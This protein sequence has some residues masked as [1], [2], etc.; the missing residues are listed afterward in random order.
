MARFRGD[1]TVNTLI[2]AAVAAIGI[3]YFVPR[4]I[5]GTAPGWPGQATSAQNQTASGATAG[6]KSGSGATP[7]PRS[8]WATSAPGRIEPVGGEVRLASQMPGRV[9]QVLVSVADKVQAG[10][11]LVK[12]DS[13]EL[14]ARVAAA[15]AEAAVRRRDRDQET[16]GRV[17]TERRT[18]EDAVATAERNA[19]NQRIELDRLVIAQRAGSAN[20]DAVK[21]ARD[22]L[23]ATRDKV[24]QSRAQLRKVLATEGM[25]LQTRLE[26]ALAGARA[27]LALADAMLERAHIRAP[28]SGSILQVFATAGEGVAPSP[29]SVL[30]VMGDVTSLRVRAEVEERDASKVRIGQPAVV[31]SDAVPGKDFTGKISSMAQALTPSRLGAKGP[32]KATDVD[33][34]ELIIDLDGQP[35]LLPG[36]RVDVFVKPDSTAQAAPRSN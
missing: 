5:A 11:L 8:V 1:S 9:A 3:A 33:V 30:L 4:Y 14:E 35:P 2:I 7:A 13:G 12:L 21:K 19:A 36:M 10:D 29:E 24:E 26:A 16:V 28:K 6:E 34:L 22:L 17:A 31:R 32:R 27:E 18:A 20:A 23:T 15:D 25:P